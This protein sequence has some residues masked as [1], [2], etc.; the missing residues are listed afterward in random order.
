MLHSGNI[1]IGSIEKETEK[2]IE[3]SYPLEVLIRIDTVTGQMKVGFL[4]FLGM[5]IDEH[6]IVKFNKSALT[7][8]PIEVNSKIKRQYEDIA[9]KVRLEQSNIIVPNIQNIKEIIKK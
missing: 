2:T 8:L 1:I 4:P 7:V 9:M 6:N 3:M 5:F